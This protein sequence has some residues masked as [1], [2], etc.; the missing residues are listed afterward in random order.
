MKRTIKLASNLKQGDKF[1]QM[2]SRF[3]GYVVKSI[4]RMQIAGLKINKIET[5]EGGMPFHLTNGTHV[6]VEVPNN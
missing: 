1:S 6:F 2:N 4:K 3:K 5:E